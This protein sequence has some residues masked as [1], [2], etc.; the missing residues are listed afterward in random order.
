MLLSRHQHRHCIL[1]KTSL[2]EALALFYR[3]CHN[4]QNTL[5]VSHQ[6]L[7]DQHARCIGFNALKNQLGNSYDA[8]FIDLSEGL[9]LSALAI[10]AGT[11]NGGG[12][13]VVHLGDDWKNRDDR[14][15]ARFL[16]W[17]MTEANHK[18]SYKCV[19]WDALHNIERTAADA[20]PSP[21]TTQWPENPLPSLTIGD[22][23]S[24][25]LTENQAA[26][27]A[28]L[29]NHTNA[30]HTLLAPRGRGKSFLLGELL[31]QAKQDNLC[32]ACTATAPHN[33]STVKHRFE[34]LNSASLPFIAPDALLANDR[35]YDLLVVDEAASLPLPMLEDMAN[36]AKTVVYSSTDFGYEG[37]GRGFGLRFSESLRQHRKPYYRHALQQPIRWAENDPLEAWLD[38]MLF[39]DFQPKHIYSTRPSKLN[40]TDWLS[41]PDLLDQA[42]ALL[43]NAHYQTNPDNKRWIVD[44]PS[45]TTFLEYEHDHLV[46]VALISEE[47]GLPDVLSEQVLQGKRRPRGHLLPQSLLAHEGFDDAGRFR[48][49]RISRIAIASDQRRLGLGSRLLARIYQG[50]QQHNIEFVATSFAATVDV[51]SFWLS[52]HYTMVRLGSGKD[53]ASGS[54]SMM[55]LRAT[56]PVANTKL[57]QWQ[58]HFS[59][60]WHRETP[61]NLR[62]LPQD[63]SALINQH[64]EIG[65]FPPLYQ[66]TPKDSADLTLFCQYH[67][68]Y[69]AIRGQLLSLVLLLLQ[70]KQLDENTPKDRLLLGCA[71][72]ILSEKDA[73]RLGFHGK[74]HFYQALKQTVQERLNQLH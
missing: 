28:T 49:W 66:F 12:L 72:N 47:G 54:Y 64:C 34:T 59:R 17:P 9:N 58:Q 46:G 65:D 11:V 4:L 74:K 16:P 48:Y 37:V 61:L 39:Q 45:V 51:L 25:E 13:L 27:I 1:S 19:F 44:D 30:L 31:H 3:T 36:K 7:D 57:E 6:A 60:Q 53:Q 18:S 69:D 73:K 56:S 24:P 41:H 38:A 62:T 8:V 2:P 52:N 14:E 70:N 33:I 55:M 68:P 40:G 63:L 35:H 20:V 42:F 32:I 50:A 22:V 10:L 5:V 23:S 21:F 26:L 15:L 67:R 71:L 29:N 43:V